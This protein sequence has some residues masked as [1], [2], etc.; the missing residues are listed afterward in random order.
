[1]VAA[2]GVGALVNL[3]LGVWIRRGSA[4]AWY[5]GM[6]L[7][8]VSVL[9]SLAA[10]AN[11]AISGGVVSGIG[12]V[13]GYLA[14]DRMLG[15]TPDAS[16]AEPS[17]GPRETDYERADAGTSGRAGRERSGQREGARGQQG[18][19][20]REPQGQQTQPRQTRGEPTAE[21]RSRSPHRQ[22][23]PSQPT[24]TT[25]EPTNASGANASS[26]PATEGAGSERDATSRGD[27]GGTDESKFCPYCGEEIPERAGHCPYCS[28][29][30]P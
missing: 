25:G 27:A 20:R 7:L 8:V 13:L 2:Y 10:G 19:P 22:E 24:D 29:A 30:M 17:A 14:K 26:R 5:A 23:S 28:E 4:Y 15:A 9:L 16:V 21:E 1:V 12:L 3:G 11:G 6:G 18:Q